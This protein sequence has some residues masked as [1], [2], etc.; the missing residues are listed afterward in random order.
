MLG[1]CGIYLIPSATLHTKCA[2][3]QQNVSRDAPD[4]TP[5]H[6]SESSN[7]NAHLAWKAEGS[8]FP[9]SPFKKTLFEI[10]R[11]DVSD[12]NK[13]N[14]PPQL[15]LPPVPHREL[16]Y[17]RLSDSTRSS[18]SKKQT[19]VPRHSHQAAAHSLLNGC[20]QTRNG[21]SSLV[22]SPAACRGKR[23]LSSS[24]LPSIPKSDVQRISRDL[25]YDGANIGACFSH[26]NRKFRCRGKYT[27][28]SSASA[29]ISDDNSSYPDV[30]NAFH[31]LPSALTSHLN[32]VFQ[33]KDESSLDL[34]TMIKNLQ[35]HHEALTL[36]TPVRMNAP[37]TSSF[38]EWQAPVD[39]I[40]NCASMDNKDESILAS[41]PGSLRYSKTDE[42]KLPM[43]TGH[44]H[45]C[46]DLLTAASNAARASSTR[47]AV[48]PVKSKPR[49]IL[50][51]AKSVRFAAFSEEITTD[52]VDGNKRLV[53]HATLVPSPL[54]NSFSLAQED[55][56]AAHN[57][58]SND[59]PP[60]LSMLPARS[61]RKRFSLPKFT[62]NTSEVV[63]KS[64]KSSSTT[65]HRISAPISR[66]ESFVS[67]RTAPVPEPSEPQQSKLARH[68]S[69][70]PHGN[71]VSAGKSKSNKD[72]TT[73]CRW[74]TMDENVARRGGS[75]ISSPEKKPSPVRL[76]Q[77]ENSKIPAL[78]GIFTRRR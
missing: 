35:K 45:Y 24:T 12:I 27:E 52:S 41:S 74:L 64:K 56:T 30:P 55:S 61:I 6:Y 47:E 50:K 65:S 43:T 54:R 72:S 23:P 9:P 76:V 78:K 42:T 7:S 31:G 46:P 48:N 19:L 2:T 38:N 17:A 4:H 28:R 33:Y 18:R 14:E 70:G 71:L 73:T 11:L 75:E 34:S 21:P 60:V 1:W 67:P 3:T 25:D 66:P 44:S 20:S 36:D 53:K 49:G 16:P 32:H 22:F 37:M 15:P 13:E 58:F 29:C 10:R 69:L 57:L 26:D 5:W 59:V 63:T 51:S 62:S 40:I 68:R 77:K 8:L 39:D